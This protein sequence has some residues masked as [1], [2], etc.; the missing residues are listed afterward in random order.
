MPDDI[1]QKVLAHLDKSVSDAFSMFSL[2]PEIVSDGSAL[3]GEGIRSNILIKGD[4]T[5]K[6]TVFSDHSSA[7]SVVSKMLG[8]DVDE[9]SEDVLDGFGEIANMIAG[10]VKTLF[11][12]DGCKFDI[13]IPGSRIGVAVSIEA[14]QKKEYVQRFYRCDKV[15]F[16]VVV[17]YQY[18]KAQ[19]VE[20]TPQVSSTDAAADLLSALIN[21]KKT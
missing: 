11:Y 12:A 21:K 20:E 4:L 8:N 13:S 2:E 5:G 9:G 7:V 16:Q 17:S 15:I 14:S 6:L 18:K 10:G 1:K 3:L 19:A